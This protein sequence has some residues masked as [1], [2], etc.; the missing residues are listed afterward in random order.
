MPDIPTA[1]FKGNRALTRY[2]FA[3]GVNACLE[4]INELINT[5]T[6]DLVS[7]ED[8]AK[9]QRL[10]EEFAAELA[11]LRG[12][13]TVLEARTAELEANQFSTTTKLTGGVIFALADVFG[14]DGGENQTVLQQRVNLTLATSFAG[15]D[16]LLLSMFAGNAP[17]TRFGGETLFGTGTFNLPGVDFSANV[18]G[19]PLS[20]TASTAEGTL[21]SQFSANTNNEL[22]IATIAYAFPLSQKLQ[23]ALVNTFAPY[24]LFAPTLNP[25][26][27]DLDGGTGAI[28]VFGEYNPLYTLV[29]GGTGAIIN[30]EIVQGLKLTAGYLADG[31]LAADAEDG[32]G[33][34]NGGYG[35]L[36]Q[37]TWNI[38]D[39]FSV[40]GVYINSYA[41]PGRFGFNYNTLGVTGTAVANTLAGQ[42]ILGSGLIDRGSG[43]ITNGYGFQFNWQPSSRVSLSGWFSTLYPRLI[44][45]GE[46]NILTYALTLAFPDLIKEGNLLG[47]VVGAEPYLT[48]FDGGNP[49]AFKVDVPIHVEAFYRF[50]LSENISITPGFI[51]L[52]SPNQ[53]ATNGDS[54][55]STVRTTFR[56]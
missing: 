20:A 29:G 36:G 28:S 19:V 10:M 39:N 26:L 38:T 37:L 6:Q 7:R 31:L 21:S 13:V 41:P 54:V 53:D 23:V 35:A 2:E 56:F 14:E 11:A 24:Q 12:R 52:I 5:S 4:R 30:Y 32:Q 16:L 51:W 17:I 49:Q 18:A 40:A 15:Y 47:M 9:L 22:I 1:P 33:L 43:V 50:Q 48:E 8:L 46:G 3:A 55:I 42:D 34:F 25:Y 44:G 27:D 45:N